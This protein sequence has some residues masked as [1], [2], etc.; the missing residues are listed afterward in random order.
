MRFRLAW[1]GVVVMTS[2]SLCSIAPLACSSDDSAATSVEASSD[3]STGVDSAVLTDGG[4]PRSFRLAAGGVQLLVSGPSLGLQITPADLQTDVDVAEIHQE[5]YGVP[6]DAFK[7]GTALPAAWDEEMKSL[8]G[9]AHAMNKPIFLSITMLNG[10]RTSLAAETTIAA[11]GSIQ[12]TDHWAPT[13]YDFAT[14]ADGAQMKAAYLAYVDYMMTTFAPA[15]LNF[16]VEVNMYFEN[17]PASIAGVVDVANAAYDEAKSKKSDVIAFPSIQIDHL[18]GF[19]S[20]CPGG[21]DAGTVRDACYESNYAQ[22]TPLKRDRFAMSS[23]PSLGVAPK[24]SDLP[25]DWFSRAASRKNETP[26]V[27]ETGWNSSSIIAELSSGT[28]YTVET[29]TEDDEEAYLDFVLRSADTEHIDLVN[30]W[31]D[32]DLVVATFMTDCPCT[33]DATWCNVL[34]QFRGPDAGPDAGEKAFYG[35]LIAKVFGTMGLRAYDGTQ[36][37]TVYARWQAALARPLTQ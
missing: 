17:C 33:F 6:W 19:G 36:K 15:Y 13:C 34:E 11:N 2:A 27:A 35:E 31:S 29:N 7:N 8:A 25:A 5:F 20:A 37:P 24:A 21:A 9:T 16:A 18:Y 26:L 28:C 1:L 10:D 30:W 14:A 3:A 4:P 22:I 12:T 23:Y 32:R